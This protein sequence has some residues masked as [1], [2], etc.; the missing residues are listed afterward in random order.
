M[1]KKYTNQSVWEATQERLEFIFQEFSQIVVSFSGGKDSGVLLNL[2]LD[3]AKKRGELHK[4]S[5]VYFD[6]EIALPQSD[7]Y[8]ERVF[9][10]LPNEVKGYWLCLPVDLECGAGDSKTWKV[11]DTSKKEFWG[12]EIPS[13]QWVVNEMN[14]PYGFKLKPRKGMNEVVKDF[15]EFLAERSGGALASL[16]GVRCSESLHRLSILTSKNR[17]NFYKGKRWSRTLKGGVTAFYPLYDWET[18]DIWTANAL[19]G[20]DYNKAY[21]LMNSL[22]MPLK[23]I[24]IASPLNDRGVDNVWIYKN[25]APQ[26]FEKLVKRVEGVEFVADYANDDFLNKEPKKRD[27]RNYNEF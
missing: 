8:V 16:V 1:I 23:K 25:L 14:L 7:E 15:I 9:N 2:T 11:W 26:A 12:K 20:W 19:N 5:V 10:N 13:N 3:F 22:G 17:V 21:D 18:E 24:R 27:L 6:Y 4:L